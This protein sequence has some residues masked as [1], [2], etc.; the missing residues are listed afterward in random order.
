MIGALICEA[1]GRET[2]RLWPCGKCPRMVCVNCLP[3]PCS[4]HAR[5]SNAG[6]WEMREE[7]AGSEVVGV[8]D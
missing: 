3:W 2:C 4:V 8:Q 5:T 7:G 6:S 1:C